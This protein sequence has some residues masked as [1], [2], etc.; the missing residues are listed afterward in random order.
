MAKDKWEPPAAIMTAALDAASEIIDGTDARINFH[1]LHSAIKHALVAA[2]SIDPWGRESVPPSFLSALSQFE[3]AV[4]DYQAQACSYTLNAR[5]PYKKYVQSNEENVDYWRREVM[6][7]QAIPS[8]IGLMHA[9]PQTMMAIFNKISRLEN[10]LAEEGII[11]VISV[12]AGDE[13]RREKERIEI[14]RRQTFLKAEE[15]GLYTEGDGA[16]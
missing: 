8:T 5:T 16:N 14:L 9:T 15:F 3:Q 1:V 6:A 2:A 7:H 10:A 11:V 4:M 13:E 12:E